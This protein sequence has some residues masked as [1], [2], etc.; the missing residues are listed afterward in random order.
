[1]DIDRMRLGVVDDTFVELF[2][3]RVF[4]IESMMIGIR[5]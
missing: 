2:D 4:L 5:G 1:M 3:G